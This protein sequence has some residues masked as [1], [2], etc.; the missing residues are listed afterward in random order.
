M[1]ECRSFFSSDDSEYDGSG[2]V[3]IVVEKVAMYDPFLELNY[4]TEL[5]FL[6]TDW[7]QW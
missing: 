5:G 4:L 1:L 7:S 2:I 3:V 6:A